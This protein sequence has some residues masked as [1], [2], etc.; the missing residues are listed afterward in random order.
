LSP[1]HIPGEDTVHTPK[2]RDSST[3]VTQAIQPFL[4]D[5][6]PF[7]LKVTKFEHSLFAFSPKSEFQ[8]SQVAPCVIA[9]GDEQAGPE[10]ETPR[11]RTRTRHRANLRTTGFGLE[12][13]RRL[14]S[15]ATRRRT[16][17]SDRYFAAATM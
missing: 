2:Y 3:S 12:D 6:T 17:R 1:P 8:S 11:I 7:S 9:V 15:R 4:Y 5:V 14:S 10:N 13:G 16:P